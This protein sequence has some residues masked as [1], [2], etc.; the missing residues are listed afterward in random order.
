MLTFKVGLLHS[1]EG[2]GA[3]A[4]SAGA[5]PKILPG[6]GAPSKFLP[7][8]ATKLCGSATLQFI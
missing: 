6:A 7:G 8:A 5:A 1:F 4:R 3:L 2:I